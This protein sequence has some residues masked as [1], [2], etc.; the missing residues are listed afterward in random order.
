MPSFRSLKAAVT[1]LGLISGGLCF[2]EADVNT[3]YLDGAHYSTACRGV[4]VGLPIGKR[5][6]DSECRMLNLAS[7][8][9]FTK[10]VHK[11]LKVNVKPET[12]AALV[13]FVYN[14]GETAFKNSKA[15][16]LI[17]AGKGADGC[18]A[19]MNWNHIG[20]NIDT[21]LTKRRAYEREYCLK[22]INKQQDSKLW[23]LFD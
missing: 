12:E 9:R 3:V 5:L 19:I 8:I 17:N 4:R 21:G 16:R 23:V 13:W 18:E 20:K 7:E 11:Y 15:L 14:I 22:G 1:A 10:I 2:L 6:T